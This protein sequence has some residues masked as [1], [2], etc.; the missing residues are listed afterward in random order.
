MF[1]T[2]IAKDLQIEGT[3]NIEWNFQYDN[4]MIQTVRT[5]GYYIPDMTVWLL[6]PRSLFQQQGEGTTGQYYFDV[7]WLGQ[8]AV[9][10]FLWF[11]L[12]SCAMPL[13]DLHVHQRRFKINFAQSLF[14]SD[15]Q[16]WQVL[17]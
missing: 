3:G 7:C 12:R 16:H 10:A 5:Q 6:S 15:E 1:F 17:A 11:H 2:G 13:R 14:E 9:L 8:H 4:D